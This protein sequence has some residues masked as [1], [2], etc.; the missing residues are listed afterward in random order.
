MNTLNINPNQEGL[1][2][3]TYVCTA[4][5]FELG[6][7]VMTQR[8][9]DIIENNIGSLGSLTIALSRHKNG[10]WGNICIEDKITND[11]ATKTGE[12]VLSEYKLCGERIWIITERDRSVTTVLLPIEY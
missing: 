8:V 3:Q 5:P 7:T 12:R 11:E 1:K 6:K 2:A 4:I 9:A 10:D